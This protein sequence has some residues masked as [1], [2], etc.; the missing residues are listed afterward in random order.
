MT[1]NDVAGRHRTRDLEIEVRGL[2]HKLAL[3]EEALAALNRR[4]LVLEHG[5][6][7]RSGVERAATRPGSP[8]PPDAHAAEELRRLQE[9]KLFRWSA[10][11]RGVY[12]SL[13]SRHRP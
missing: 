12:G 5:G 8:V 10:R 4:L 2:R 7:G 6:N 9:T 1:G 11:A 13:L 3:R